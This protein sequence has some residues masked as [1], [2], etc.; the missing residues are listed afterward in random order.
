VIG[1]ILDV[2]G[3]LGL[4]VGLVYFLKMKRIE[5]APF[6]PTGQVA[7]NPQLA[8]PKGMV[9]A[10]G[11]IIA[12]QPVMAPISG[13]P[14]LYYEITITR[15]WEK[16]ETTQQGT[17]DVKGSD[18][19]E[20][21][22]VGAVFQIN[23]G[24]GPVWVDARE[25]ADAD[26]TQTF[27]DRHPIGNMIPGEI[28]FGQMRMQTPHNHGNQRT[29]AFRA[30][31]KVLPIEGTLYA[32][33]KLVNGG[34]AKP[35]WRSL[36][37]SHKG[38]EALLGSS[39]K[40]AMVGFIVGGLMLVGSIPA[41]IFGPKMGSG[42]VAGPSCPLALTD[43]QTVCA[44]HVTLAAGKDYQWTVT[45]PGKYKVTVLQPKFKNAID[46]TIN[47]KDSTGARVGYN[48]GNAPGIDPVVDEAFAAGTYTLNVSDFSHRTVTGGFDFQLL[49]ASTGPAA[50]PPSASAPA[51]SAEPAPAKPP[52]SKPEP[53]PEPKPAGHGGKK[54]H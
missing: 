40:L 5:G 8:D 46:A 30:V 34:I 4:I 24:S 43:A 1:M 53:K 37:L 39:K 12:Q 29:L 22:K 19:I 7:S 49:I 42:T 9:S 36:I 54:H 2:L 52:P 21:R 6:H 48:D 20:T 10:Q 28:Q 51:A 14:C 45:K 33:G 13:R 18:T 44:D 3:F 32:A 26:L 11:N 50:P 17:R 31:E 41:W 38:R 27:N 16:Q 35:G 25:G 23:D 47:I 15:E